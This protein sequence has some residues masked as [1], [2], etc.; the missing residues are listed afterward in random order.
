MS[1]QQTSRMF[2]GGFMSDQSQRSSEAAAKEDDGNY[3][4]IDGNAH[5]E[6]V[7]NVRSSFF[8]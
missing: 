1:G 3:Y 5:L 4:D 7:L 8:F 2:A 6:S